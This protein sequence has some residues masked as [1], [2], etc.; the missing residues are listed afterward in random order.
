MHTD[1]TKRHDFLL[2]VDVE[3]G[4]PN[5]DPD[6]G[7]APRVDYETGHGLISDVCIK[8]KIRN[9]VDLV[10]DNQEPYR[11]YVRDDGTPLN[12]RHKSC[13]EVLGLE[14]NK[15]NTKPEIQEQARR[16]MC[17]MYYDVRMMGAVM[18]T[19]DH[20]CSRVRGP[21]Q[22]GFGCSVDPV[23][24]LPIAIT[25]CAITRAGDTLGHGDEE[26]GKVTEMGRK[27]I[28]PYAV[29]GV[30]GY[31]SAPLAAKTGV[32]TDDLALLWEA[33]TGMWDHDHSAVRATMACRGIFVWSH[34]TALGN[35]PAHQ[36]LGRI[37]VRRR[38]EVPVGRSWGDYEVLVAD[39]DL[40]AGVTPIVLGLPTEARAAA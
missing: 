8:R 33:L 18:S 29:Y 36:L 24:P 21:L 39:A 2:L 4:N 17:E 28:I 5:G 11:I 9:Y 38:E 37:T 6:A 35:A 25:R 7:G 10:R 16:K 15:K 3:R 1:P 19:G 27:T 23:G 13:Y 30:K 14:G 40:P 22:F 20:P 26:G 31:F 12:D 34:D 32:T